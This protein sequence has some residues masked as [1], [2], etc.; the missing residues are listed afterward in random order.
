M[1]KITVL[2]V[3]LFF[4]FSGF[5][6]ATGIGAR[7]ENWLQNSGP[8]NSSAIGE[9][10]EPENPAITPIGEGLLILTML[11]GGYVLSRKKNK[12]TK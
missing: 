9:E 12:Q 10:D 11:S 4:T 3:V 6:G 1:K 5:A 7:V 2:T 8:S